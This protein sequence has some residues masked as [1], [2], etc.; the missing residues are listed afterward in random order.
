MTGTK[1]SWLWKILSWFD[2][3][4]PVVEK[5]SIFMLASEAKL[6]AYCAAEEAKEKR[7]AEA[8]AIKEKQRA[9][10]KQSC[11]NALHELAQD[12]ILYKQLYEG[13]T[14]YEFSKS[15]WTSLPVVYCSDPDAPPYL[16]R[17][18]LPR[19]NIGAIWH[20]EAERRQLNHNR[21]VAYLKG[22]TL[23]NFQ[24]L[25]ESTA[26]KTELDDNI[27]EIRAELRI[28]VQVADDMERIKELT[29]PEE[30]F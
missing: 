6:D 13:M 30:R 18:A 29:N 14:N 10:Y 12:E 2:P 15:S 8:K 3:E 27:P 24:A 4:E 7:E 11:N 20:A 9:H 19:A 5:A 23:V 17:V 28:R 25:V 22:L 1:K 16:S 21:F 26:G